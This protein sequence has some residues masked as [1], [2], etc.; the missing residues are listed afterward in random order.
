MVKIATLGPEGTFSDI[1]TQKYLEDISAQWDVRYFSSLDRAF[2]AI[3]SEC[4][5]GV[6]PIENLSEGFV[7]PVLDLLVDAQLN[8]IHEILLP[9]R[10]SFISHA[11]TLSKVKK[12]FVQFMAKG[13]CSG[14]L[15]SLGDVENVA[16]ESNIESLKM[17]HNNS[18][19][20]A[21]VP[22]HAI[23]NIPYSVSIDNI[24]DYKNNQ[25][26]FIV[27]ENMK[28]EFPYEPGVTYKTSLII[29]DDNDYPGLL[30]SILS[31]FSSRGINLSSIMSRPT[32]DSMGKYH[33]FIDI[34]GHVKDESV[35]SALKEIEK[36]NKIKILG[37]YRKA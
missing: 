15:D 14:F 12:V 11:G 26:R 33:F 37:S 22:S 32:K 1:A 23:K 17:I 16:T 25:T 3:G 19:A 35:K 36:M 28:K 20:G 4:E 10:F 24:N 34:E 7:Q 5:Y 30:V 21:I 18:N 6:L 27:L 8:I 31:G 2:H 9:I 13:Q 29:L